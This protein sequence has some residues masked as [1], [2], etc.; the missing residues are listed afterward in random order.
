MKKNNQNNNFIPPSA[1]PVSPVPAKRSA[2]PPVSVKFY[3]NSD[4]CKEKIFSE[5][6]NKSGIYMWKNSINDKRYIGSSNNLKRRFREYFNNNYLLNNNYMAICN[7]LIKHG[8]SNF[9]LYILEYCSV[10][11]L[12]IREKHYLGLLKPEY[13]ISQDPT[14]PFS[15]RT[16]SDATKI[17]MS[18][19]KKGIPRENNPMFGKNHS[20]KTKTIMSDAKKGENNPMFSKNHSEETKTIMSEAKKGRPRTEGAGR[21]SQQIEVT[22]ITNNTTTSYD[23]ISEAARA[24]NLSSYKIISTYFKQ[25]QKKPYKGQY[26]FKKV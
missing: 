8:Y 4:T 14:A 11:D 22:D 9:S 3:P 10:A 21:P 1:P 25:N 6:I 12:L 7:S 20:D 5:N 2:E 19:A 16:H 18:D 23:S 26:T 15:G 13:N 24:L 17:I